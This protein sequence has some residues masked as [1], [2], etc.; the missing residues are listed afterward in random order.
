MG[1]LLNHFAPSNPYHL[2]ILPLANAL[3]AEWNTMELGC[4]PRVPVS[5][6]VQGTM[7][8]VAEGGPAKLDSR[9]EQYLWVCGV[10]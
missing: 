1:V 10:G 2:Q 7:Y 8:M 6:L 9:G 4:T 3:N 5:A